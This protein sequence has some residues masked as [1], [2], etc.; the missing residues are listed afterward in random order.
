ML[1]EIRRTDVPEKGI[2]EKKKDSQAEKDIVSF[3]E[4]GMEAAE[5]TGI[6]RYKTPESACS[7]YLAKAKILGVWPKVRPVLRGG[8]VFIIREG[9]DD[10]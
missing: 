1:K 10:A 6:E 5:V 8:R 7:A 9:E 3:L 2:F 4:S